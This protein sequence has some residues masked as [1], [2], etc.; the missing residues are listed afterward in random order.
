MNSYPA[1]ILDTSKLVAV[2]YVEA[3]KANDTAFLD[4]L[5]ESIQDYDVIEE[6]KDL[7]RY[8]QK[9]LVT[10][11]QNAGDPEVN[12]VASKQ[13]GAQR[14]F[15]KMQ[16]LELEK[17]RGRHKRSPKSEDKEP[18][19]PR[20]PRENSI[21]TKAKEVIRGW[22]REMRD[23]PTDNSYLK[24]RRE[25]VAE[26]VEMFDLKPSTAGQYIQHVRAENK[27]VL[28]DE[29]S[30]RQRVIGFM[31]AGIH[32]KHDRKKVIADAVKR[33]ELKESTLKNYYQRA[34]HQYI[35]KQ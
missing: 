25:M 12:R 35:N 15:A 23:N 5:P 19:K 20:A 2:F 1:I 28:P 7:E 27:E 26:L 4:K 34:R 32:M 24:P 13:K 11:I 17:F 10:I 30:V 8:T 33:F 29:G 6:P 22:F 3:D 14:A 16:E 18:P 21:H 31:K 9:E